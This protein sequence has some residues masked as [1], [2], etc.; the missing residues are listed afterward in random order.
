[1]LGNGGPRMEAAIGRRKV[2]KPAA[3]LWMNWEHP[4]ADPDFTQPLN[5]APSEKTMQKSP[6]V[7]DKK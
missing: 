4:E 6:N 7:H 1:M 5:I 2:E 3:A